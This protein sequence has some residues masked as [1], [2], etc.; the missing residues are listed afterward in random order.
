MKKK[1]ISALFC[2]LSTS[3]LAQIDSTIFKGTLTNKE[4]NVYLKIDFYHQNIKVPGQEIFG[5]MPGYFGDYQDGRKWLI[6]DISI[7]TEREVSMSIINDYGS[8]DLTAEIT[9]TDDGKYIFKQLKG[10]TMKIARN[11][12]WL[13]IPKT[14]EFVRK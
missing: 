7:I 3:C 13:K 11:R 8:E 4:Y 10:S 12:K 6:T 5:E 2:M 1:L 14:L 9:V